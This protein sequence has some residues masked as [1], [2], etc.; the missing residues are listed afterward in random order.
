MNNSFQCG[1]SSRFLTGRRA[2]RASGLGRLPGILVV[3]LALCPALTPVWAGSPAL[4]LNAVD[5]GWYDAYNWSSDPYAPTN[6]NGPDGDSTWDVTINATGAAYGVTLNADT[7]IDSLLLD[8]PDATV[9]SSG[10]IEVLGTATLSQG[11]WRLESGNISGGLWNVSSDARLV[12]GSAFSTGELSGVTVTGGIHLQDDNAVGLISGG[13]TFTTAHL[14]GADSVLVFAPGETLT[15]TVLFEGT[16]MGEH[17]VAVDSPGGILTIGAGGVIRTETGLTGGEDGYHNHIGLASFYGGDMDLQHF[18]LISSEVSAQ[19]ISIDAATFTNS[20]TLRASNGGILSINSSQWTQSG[21]ITADA[22]STVILGG[23]FTVG[24]GGTFDNASGGLISLTGVLDNTG[25]T[26]NLASSWTIDGG[27]ITGGAVNLASG[28]SLVF[29]DNPWSMLDG[30]AVDGDLDLSADFALARID[31][32]TSFHT[33]HLGGADSA[34]G[35]ADG[36]T[37]S[38]TILFEGPAQGTRSVEMGGGDG[39]LTISATGQILTA[40]D[41][42]NSDFSEADPSAGYFNPNAIG[43]FGWMM[44]IENHGLISSRTSGQFILAQT[45]VLTNHDTG[46]IEAAN[47]GYAVFGIT[48]FV[49]DGLVQA[50]DGGSL[51][52]LSETFT[53]NSTGVIQSLRGG[54]LVVGGDD[55]WTNGGKI[56]VDAT[57]SLSLSGTFDI[58]GGLGDFDNSAGGTVV[59]VGDLLNH[60]HNL[61]LNSLTGS[62]TLQDGSILGGSLSFADG[63]TLLVAPDSYNIIDGVDV[64][65]DL[66]IPAGATDAVLSLGEGTTFQ[67]AHLAA[68]NSALLFTPG[69]TLSGTILFEGSA[70]GERTVGPDG[71]DG[72]H[73]AFTIGSTGVIRT[74]PDLANGAS[75]IIGGGTASLGLMDLTNEGLI[76]SQTAGQLISV[77]SAW[78]LNTGIMEARDG[79]TLSVSP[80]TVLE[81]LSGG[82]LGGGVWRVA[83]GTGGTTT[84]EL[85][86]GDILTN[87]A[88]VI[89]SGPDSVFA[90]LGTLESNEGV[91]EL[92]AG[93]VFTSAGDFSN[94]GLINL[95][96]DTTE[97]ILSGA[98]TNTAAGKVSLAGG[99]LTGT[100][101][102]NS[103]TIS[104]FGTVTERPLNHGTIQA[105]GG[106]LVF[107]HGIQGGSGTV[108]ID[109]GASLDLSAG[110]EG[111]DADFLI[112]QGTTPGSLNLGANDFRVD[113]D[114]TNDSAGS[115]NSY[116]PRANV[117]GSGQIIAGGDAAQ[118]LTGDVS[119]GATVSPQ[120]DFGNVHVG[121]A[122]TLNYQVANTGS[123]GPSIRG[124]LQSAAGGG[125]ITDSRLSGAG[126]AAGDFG[127]LGPGSDSGNLGVTFTA[128]SAGA[129]SGQAVGIVSN[130]GN[131]PGQTL[132]ITGAAFRF[133]APAIPAGT[134][135]SLGIVHVGDTVSQAVTLNNEADADSFSESLNASFSGS[136]P[137][138]TTGGAVALLAPGASSGGSLVVG[139]D[140]SSASVINGT[141]TLSLSSDGAGSSG[142]GVS[143]LPDSTLNVSGQVNNYAAP[144]FLLASG[145][146]TFT[147]DSVSTWTLDFGTVNNSSTDGA[148]VVALSLTNDVSGPS[149]TLA[150][151]FLQVG[152]SFQFSNLN[153][154][155]GLEAGQILTNYEV[156]L[157]NT[158]N[159][160]F[161][162]TITLS[163]SSQNSGGYDGGLGD[164][165][166]NIT[167]TVVPEPSAAAMLLLVAA[168]GSGLRRNRL[169]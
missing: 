113:I 127:P 160:S 152:D 149:D 129:L 90:E 13:T 139:L 33:A 154:F 96:D 48:D 36:Q 41:L 137:G 168:A 132:S 40:A 67:T 27:L 108:Q 1:F 94:S 107:G 134:S 34:I 115:G 105:A 121:S 47:G 60:G 131:I 22:G 55:P 148:P 84:L 63:K 74:A 161:S 20:G 12:V 138:I 118:H 28:A 68:E 111:S 78:L 125:N 82:T 66:T 136:D 23:E 5:G 30:V 87:R 57:S 76:S 2:V 61:T 73:G 91:L 59:I 88:A 32:G 11:I 103:G 7:V 89:L 124:A 42:K 70:A 45:D 142:L 116:D 117:S 31:G 80:D 120:L 86:H 92:A 25:N 8:S 71:E 17:H 37:L 97:L 72:D 158:E 85:N 14:S 38:G 54:D 21:A 162:G 122:S 112:H 167:G 119:N 144:R 35:F 79:G 81:N 50:I 147:Q 69:E 114:Y 4:W 109:P 126:V 18:G 141:A 99:H 10:Q 53:N 140:T 151:T 58:T 150:G 101:I 165:V 164:F 159:G 130:F 6:G 83:S 24:A 146:G 95:V 169:T 77:E 123:T 43:Y 16:A 51:V 93:R 56:L 19:E 104:G 65:G 102:T 49:N 39:T 62:W 166:I 156:T 75:N 143:T 155:S 26:L 128:D 98:F 106:A 145:P 15:G 44:S 135:V 9:I 3:S 110:T 153:A 163:G 133:A 52:M 64:Q 157:D 46:T 29:T 100:D